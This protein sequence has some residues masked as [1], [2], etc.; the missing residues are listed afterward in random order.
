MTSFASIRPSATTAR[1]RARKPSELIARSPARFSEIQVTGVLKHVLRAALINTVLAGLLAEF[2]APQ[3][4]WKTTHLWLGVKVAISVVR[5]LASLAASFWSWPRYR[6]PFVRKLTLV[7]LG[8][9]GAVWGIG[10][11]WCAFG[12]SEI[13]CLTCAV[14]CSVSLMATHGFN[15]MA[16]ASVSYV[17]PML[18]PLV[19]AVLFRG[20]AIGVFVAIGTFLVLVQSVVTS[21]ASEKRVRS[22]FAA[23][24]A[25]ELAR[26]RESLNAVA[27]EAALLEV[28]RQAAVKTLFLGTMSHELR[29]PLH[30]I[31][32]LS[33]L[34]RQQTTDPVAQH[35]LQLLDSSG[36]HLLELIGSL[37]D[38]SRIESGRLELHPTDF[39]LGS[40]LQNVSDLYALRCNEKGLRFEQ[41]LSVGSG[42]M[43]HGDPARIRQ[44]LHNLLGNAVKFTDAGLVLFK[45]YRRDEMLFFEV[46]DTGQGIH[47]TDIE[48]IFDA[49]GQAD[50]SATRPADG[51]GLGLTIAREL[52][53]AM[54]G[55]VT[56][57]SALGV[58]TQF[59]FTAR[60]KIAAHVSPPF[61]APAQTTLP[62]LR[63]GYRVLLV[64]DNE[65]NAVIATAHLSNLGAEVVRAQNGA[66]AVAAAF[67]AFRPNFI[68]MDCRMPVM[69]GPTATREIR[70]LEKQHSAAAIPI[71]ALTASPTEDDKREC[72][73]SGMDGFLSKPFSVEQLLQAI[74][75]YSSPEVC[76]HTHP[77]YEYARSLDD[78]NLEETH[79]FTRH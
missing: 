69:D 76:D 70:R 11:A 33:E 12:P 8:V 61:L 43:V 16:S 47:A 74:T 37:L 39:D 6:Q 64:E 63:S 65:V 27:L 71:V 46:R 10:G 79:G 60:L 78:S 21:I 30:G 26:E 24:D 57:T 34:L 36:K 28:K 35:R 1:I 45:V 62:H 53:R 13:A 72:Y 19:V 2:L 29:T 49:F 25:T 73:E 40:E 55:D 17:T 44:V 59:L 50:D 68:F 77:L 23:H 66:E 42:T 48:H 54:E 75:L 18:L 7:L 51:T 22:E 15:T 31:L 38:V 5:V 52:A 58:G 4:G 9:D 20:D 32:G 67:A 41:S 14:L 56:V 3:F